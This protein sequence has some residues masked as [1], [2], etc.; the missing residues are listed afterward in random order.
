[1]PLLQ[2]P[3][4]C[5]C[6]A[7]FV[8]NILDNLPGSVRM[9]A[10]TKCGRSDLADPVVTEDRP[11]DVQLHGY[12]LFDLSEEAREWASAWPRYAVVNQTRIYLPATARFESTA[13]RNAA[14][15]AAA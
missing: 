1:M 12:N 6:L 8:L 10:C 11:Y 13:E 4:D 14:L 15:K 2:K 7:E 3:V 5:D 9:A